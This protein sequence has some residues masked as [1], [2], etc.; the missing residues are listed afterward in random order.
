MKLR[1]LKQ[2]KNFVNFEIAKL[3]TYLSKSA[4]VNK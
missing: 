3:M 2:W 4:D 1:I